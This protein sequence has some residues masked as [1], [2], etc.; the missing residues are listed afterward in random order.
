MHNFINTLKSRGFIHQVINLKELIIKSSNSRLRAYIGF[1]CTAESLHAGS[2][3]QIMILKWLQKFGHQPIILLGGG[4]TKVGDPS[5]KDRLRKMLNFYNIIRN[6]QLIQR[7][8][9]QFLNIY[10]M[11]KIIFLDNNNW[12]SQ[13]QYMKFLI[14]FGKYFSIN[15]MISFDSVQNRLDREQSL[16]FLELNYTLLQAFD[17]YYLYKEHECILQFGGSDQWNNIITGV[18]LVKKKSNK[19]LFGLTSP[20]FTTNNG[21][22]MGKTENGAIWLDK[23]IFSFYEYWQFWRNIEDHDIIKFLKLFTALSLNEIQR[24]SKL[25]KNN[26]NSL[27][28]L[29][30]DEATGF[31][32]KIK[33]SIIL[34]SEIYD[35]CDN[36]ISISILLKLN[37]T[38][39]N[40]KKSIFLYKILVLFNA[41]QSN[42]SAKKIIKKNY[43]KINGNTINNIKY[44]IQ[45]IDFINSKITL[46]IKKKYIT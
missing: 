18:D 9:S 21:V 15:K 38:V 19:Q 16:S 39:I 26:I 6:K 37:I 40:I 14:F 33:N 22:K 20:L 46:S 12:L 43:I 27:K 3:I 32:H 44:I 29:L 8:F 10:T 35:T 31:C 7:I 23:N 30:A 1:D 34:K 45:K 24:L 42:N 5:G 2:L 25:T 36:N 4:T 28:I 41:A 13:L 11:N 17:F